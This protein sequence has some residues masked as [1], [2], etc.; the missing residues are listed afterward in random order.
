MCGFLNLNVNQGVI[1]AKSFQNNTINNWTGLVNLHV[2]KKWLFGEKFK[3]QGI[4]PLYKVKN[5][6]KRTSF[7]FC[8]DSQK[9]FR[10][11]KGLFCISQCN[12]YILLRGIDS[13]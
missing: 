1:T 3:C 13:V 4:R 8:L 9:L 2:L 7:I 6:N 5:Q 10:G 12:F 11:L